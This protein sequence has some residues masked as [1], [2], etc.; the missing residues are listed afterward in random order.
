MA[1]FCLRPLIVLADA[2]VCLADCASL[3][4]KHDTNGQQYRAKICSRIVAT[5]GLPL[6][7]DAIS[8][9]IPEDYLK[10]VKEILNHL[11]DY[12]YLQNHNWARP[13]LDEGLSMSQAG[14]CDRRLLNTVPPNALPSPLL[15]GGAGGGVGRTKCV[16]PAISRYRSSPRRI[17][18]PAQSRPARPHR[19]SPAGHR[20]SFR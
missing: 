13:F 12:P 14:P 19:P 8:P 9:D 7:A 3:V 4:P 11:Y 2:P 5:R 10:H 20:L 18:D 17:P 1:A 15:W 6:M 16:V